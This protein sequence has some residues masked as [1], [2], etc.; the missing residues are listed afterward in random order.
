M[1]ISG[2]NTHLTSQPNHDSKMVLEL[3]EFKRHLPIYAPSPKSVGHEGGVV[4]KIQ[5]QGWIRLLRR[6]YKEETHLT[7]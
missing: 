2:S 1:F 4:G 5:I 3:V 7:L 6:V